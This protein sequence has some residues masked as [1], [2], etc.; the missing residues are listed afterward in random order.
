MKIVAKIFSYEKDF[1]ERYGLLRGT[2]QLVWCCFRSAYNLFLMLIARL[3][4]QPDSNK[5][6]FMSY[7]DYTD[8][9]RVLSEYIIN[10][11]EQDYKVYWLV[12]D[13]G[14]NKKIYGNNKIE[15]LSNKKESY[16]YS[17]E[18]ISKVYSCG[19][20]CYTNGFIFDK[21]YAN[22]RQKVIN[23]W[24]G[25]GYKA[26]PQK[27]N[28]TFD[29]VLVPGDAFVKTKSE[30]FNVNPEK[31]FPI[32]YPR[33]DLLRRDSQKAKDF[34]SGLKKENKK[35]IIWMPTF[36]KTGR[37]YFPEENN[38]RVFESEADLDEY[39]I[40]TTALKPSLGDIVFKN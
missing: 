25:C 14:L 21:K 20:L 4:I 6:A 27:E 12:E 29:C 1:I 24:H 10:D 33:Y 17:W 9:A 11:L 7:P 19:I 13:V 16:C 39:L 15:F 26:A 36:R 3:V 38:N 32:G 34:I 40:V 35:F 31:V 5:I 2:L 18:T 8:S 22:P 28:V 37:T 30:F 23:L